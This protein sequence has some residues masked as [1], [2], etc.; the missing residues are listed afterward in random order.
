MIRKVTWSTLAVAVLLAACAQKPTTQP[1]RSGATCAKLDAV[2]LPVVPGLRGGDG[3]LA[4]GR[5]A[6]VG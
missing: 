2:Q 6:A 4:A 1:P 5:N 3:R